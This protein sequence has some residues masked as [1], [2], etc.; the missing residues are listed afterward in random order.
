MNDSVRPVWV[1]PEWLSWLS[2]TATGQH[3]GDSAATSRLYEIHQHACDRLASDPSDLDRVDA[4]I[5]LRR[6]IGRR[7]KALIEIHQLRELPTGTKPKYDLELLEYFGIIR[8]YMLKRLIDIRNL[9]EHEDSI[10]PSTD[11]CLVNNQ[12]MHVW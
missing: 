9:V 1:D 5:A 11:E 2:Y 3:I 6:V 12:P 4:I 8:P 10:P 7:V